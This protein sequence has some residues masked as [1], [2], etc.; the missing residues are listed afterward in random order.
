[1]EYAAGTKLPRLVTSIYL[2]DDSDI[3]PCIWAKDWRVNS[4]ELV[5]LWRETKGNLPEGKSLFF[6]WLV[7]G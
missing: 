7:C 6:R 3:S 4:L 1:M 2:Y 5:V